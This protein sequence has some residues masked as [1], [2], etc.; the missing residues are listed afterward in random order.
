[1][2]RAVIDIGTNSVLLLVADVSDDGAVTALYDAA[3]ITRL[4]E[5]IERENVIGGEALERTISAIAGYL[6]Q[7]ERYGVHD[8]RLIGTEVFREP[9]NTREVQDKIRQA[10]GCAVNVLTPLQEAELSFRSVLP[11]DAVQNQFIL[12]LD[13]GG[14][15]T[16]I[17]WG[18]AEGPLMLR[19]MPVGCVFLTERFLFHDP[20]WREE[21]ESMRGEIRRHLSRLPELDEK[22][23]AVG[24]GGTV[25]TLAA[26]HNK[27]DV[28]D[29]ARIDGT[30]LSRDDIAALFKR[31]CRISLNRRMKLKGMEQERADIITAGAA[32]LAACADHFGLEKI[33]VSVRGVRYG[34]AGIPGS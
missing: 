31:F 10:T 24:I 15:S 18:D 7:S 32:I 11:A 34:Y 30:T 21:L 26:V 2:R 3:V 17:A 4:G 29:P 28:Y 5:G 20:P 8:V 25:T 33:R 9:A 6:K 23:D 14:G 19:S 12:V 1:M 27:L 16:E 22:L 13:I